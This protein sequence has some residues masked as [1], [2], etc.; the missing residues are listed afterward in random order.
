[1]RP[2]ASR[3]LHELDDQR[4]VAQRQ[5]RRGL[6]AE[7]RQPVRIRGP[8]VEVPEHGAELEHQGADPQPAGVLDPRPRVAAPFAGKLVDRL[9]DGLARTAVL[10]DRVRTRPNLDPP[11]SPRRSIGGGAPTGR[12][13]AITAGSRVSGM[14]VASR[15]RSQ[16]SG[17]LPGASSRGIHRPRGSMKPS[18][19]A[20][21]GSRVATTAYRP[22]CASPGQAAGAPRHQP[23]T[24]HRAVFA[25]SRG[26]RLASTT[27]SPK[28]DA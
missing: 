21:R 9:L 2:R 8:A 10:D 12:S 17:P 27:W 1:M 13:I 3:R 11:Q 23:A 16:R 4:V 25:E 14:N 26:K 24:D 20:A 19:V 18:A 5:R 6:G 28:T 15:T 7:P 22:A